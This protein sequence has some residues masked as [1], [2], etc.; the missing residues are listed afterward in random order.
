[1]H[2]S[3]CFWHLLNASWK[4]CSV[5]MFSKAYK[6]RLDHLNCIKTA[7]FQLY[8][9][10]GKQKSCPGHR[11]VWKCFGRSSATK[12]FFIVIN[13]LLHEHRQVRKCI[14][15]RYLDT[16]QCA[17]LLSVALLTSVSFIVN[18]CFLFAKLHQARYTTQIKGHNKSPLPPSCVKFCTPT[19]KMCQ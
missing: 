17:R 15:C 11:A 6:F 8:L 10:S 3:Q 2:H 9:H 1:M 7:A 14:E 12:C 16:D 5:R 18:K 13:N 19:C 4:S